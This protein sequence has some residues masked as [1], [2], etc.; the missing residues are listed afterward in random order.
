MKRNCRTVCKQVLSLLFAIVMLFSVSVEGLAAIASNPDDDAYILPVHDLPEMDY[1]EGM[2]YIGIASAEGSVKEAG[3]YL[4][5]VRRTGDVSVGSTVE[6]R[7]VDVS[8]CYG[9]DYVIDDP[10]WQT[11]VLPQTETLVKQYGNEANR[12]SAAQTLTELEEMI[13][14]SAAEGEKTSD[15]DSSVTTEPESELARLKMEQTGL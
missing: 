4:L 6:L 11:E 13:S 7:T 9:R 1:V 3:S 10:V 5:T 12:L 8:A 15:K 14:E 2:P